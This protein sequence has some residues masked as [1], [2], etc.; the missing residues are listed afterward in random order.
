MK[1]LFT[2]VLYNLLLPAWTTQLRTSIEELRSTLKTT[3]AEWTPPWVTLEYVGG[4]KQITQTYND[5]DNKSYARFV[6]PV[7][8]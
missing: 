2:Y 6:K 8:R 4:P 5:P 3:H 7:T 1:L